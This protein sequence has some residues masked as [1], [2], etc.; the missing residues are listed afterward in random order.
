M[1]FHVYSDTLGIMIMQ[2]HRKSRI[3]VNFSPASDFRWVS[4]IIQ[5]WPRKCRCCG[6]PKSAKNANITGEWTISGRRMQPAEW[7]M[8]VK[9][10]R[11]QTGDR[12]SRCVVV[13]SGTSLADMP[14]S[15]DRE[16]KKQTRASFSTSI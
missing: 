10:Q 12:G 3:V 13:N 1:T 2:A 8:Q 6:K 14:E 15:S 4:T 16:M 11:G 5:Q 7:Q 9:M